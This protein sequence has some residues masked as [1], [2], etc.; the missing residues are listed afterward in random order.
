MLLFP[1]PIVYSAGHPR[2][3][4]FE[5]WGERQFKAS[6]DLSWSAELVNWF[7]PGWKMYQNQEASATVHGRFPQQTPE[8]AEITVNN[9]K[10]LIFF[11]TAMKMLEF[12]A[13]SSQ[14]CHFLI[15]SIFICIQFRIHLHCTLVFPKSWISLLCFLFCE[16]CSNKNIYCIYIPV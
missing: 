12:G 15:F 8:I 1:D 3:C 9:N 11:V 7:A 2:T 10:S 4:H 6:S 14:M 16:L 13:N 5:L